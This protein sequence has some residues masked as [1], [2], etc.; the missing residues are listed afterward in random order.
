[1]S[2]IVHSIARVKAVGVGLHVDDAKL[3]EEFVIGH[4]GGAVTVDALD[5]CISSVLQ[6]GRIQQRWVVV[7]LVEADI[8][9]G[10]PADDAFQSDLRRRG[11][12]KA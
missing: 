12:G 8:R 10:I 7:A 4:A 9:R 11:G 6:F 1:M 3:V 2:E 5:V